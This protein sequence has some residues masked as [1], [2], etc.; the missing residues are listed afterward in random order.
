MVNH[1][2]NLGRK[3]EPVFRSNKFVIFGLA[4]IYLLGIIGITPT[5]ATTGSASVT[6]SLVVPL[7]TVP[8]S[9][10]T[11]YSSIISHNDPASPLPHAKPGLPVESTKN[12]AG[13]YQIWVHL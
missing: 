4:L 13:N 12:I 1:S 7:Q 5:L 3:G 9:N 11:E 6:L 8:S 2:N 10:Q